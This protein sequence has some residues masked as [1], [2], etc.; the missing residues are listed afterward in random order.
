MAIIWL[1]VYFVFRFVQGTGAAGALKGILVL[2]VVVTLIARILSGDAFG[3]LAFL[4]DRLLGVVAI[5]AGGHL[6]ARA[7]PGGHQA[8]RVALFKQSPK[9]IGNIVDQMAGG[10]RLSLQGQVRRVIVL[11]RQ[12]Q[13]GGPDR[14][15]HAH[16]GGRSAR[17]LQTIFHP[18]TALHDLAVIVRGKVIHAA[19]V[20]LP[21]AD[22]KTCPIRVWARGTGRVLASARSVMLSSSLSASL[23]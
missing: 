21:L 3:R 15:R 9:D 12:V 4:Y 18:G 23:G 13:A 2:F 22:P 1:V 14:G 10:L 19:G 6:P 16:Q 17:L 5:A 20:Q 7:S 8:G 11:E